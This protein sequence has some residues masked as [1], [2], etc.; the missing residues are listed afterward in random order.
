MFVHAAPPCGTCSRAREIARP[1]APRPLRTE[2]QPLGRDGLTATEQAR[3]DAANAI[4]A[5]LAD[6]F[7]RC[8]AMDIPWSVENPSRSLLWLIPCIR[9]LQDVTCACFYNYD[10]CA[11]GSKRLLQRSFLSTL[12]AMCGIQAL[13]ANDHEHLSLGRTRLPDASTKWDTAD[14]AA[15]TIPLCKQ[16]VSVVQNAL[17]LWPQKQSASTTNVAINQRG[18]VALQKQPRGRK[19]PPVMSEFAA[20]TTVQSTD[21]PPLDSKGCLLRAFHGVPM[22]SKLLSFSKVGGN[23]GEHKITCK[24]GIYRSPTA[25]LKDACMLAH[26]F[27]CYHAVPDAMLRVIFELLTNSPGDVAR[28][29]AERLKLWVSWAHQLD[30]QEKDLKRNLEAGVRAILQP[31][32]VLLMKRIAQEMDWPDMKLFDDMLAGFDIVGLQEPSHVFGLEPRPQIISAEELWDVSKFVRPALLGKVKSSEQDADLEELWRI[33]LEE[34][35][36]NGWMLGPFSVEQMHERTGGK[37]W[38]PVRRFGV[39]Q[40]SGDKTKLRPIDDYAENRVNSAFGYSDKL[41]LRTLDQVIWCA[42]AVVRCLHEGTV[43]FFLSDGSVLSG[44]L[45]EAYRNVDDGK[46]VISVLDLASA[47]KQFALSPSCRLMSIITL[48]EPSTGQ[49]KCFE[50]RVLPFGATASVVHFHRISKFLQAIGFQ[51]LVLWGNY[52]D[53]Y[54]MLSTKLLADSTMQTATTLLDLLGFEFAGHKLKPFAERASVLGVDLDLSSAV[55]DGVIRVYNKPSRVAE[56]G[57]LVRQVLDTQSITSKEASRLLGRLQFADSQ[58]M[59]RM[60]RLVMHDFRQHVRSHA[61]THSLDSSALGSLRMLLERLE[62]GK[63]KE[64]PCLPMGSPVVIFTDGASEGDDHTIGG[65]VVDGQDIEFFSCRV[66]EALIEKWQ[67]IF[68]HVIG[69][70]ELYAVLVAA[71]AW[72]SKITGRRSLFFIDNN[73][74]M[75]SLIKGTSGPQFYRELLERWECM[76]CVS[77]SWPWIARIPSHSNPADE[78]SRGLFDLMT[79]LKATRCDRVQCPVTGD[80]LRNL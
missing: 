53:D 72:A 17:K 11:W 42:A 1:N 69:L 61:P 52:F 16:I 44:R 27:D 29:R 25:W 36:A 31:K 79:S 45:H 39:W 67:S 3:V 74:A 8:H 78:P 62:K 47:Y 7:T 21:M 59:G 28:R 71:S 60:G 38:I 37:P 26:P 32:R 5:G 63:P 80:T 75:D 40:T 65:L 22:H 13:C 68:S 2:L 70:I 55:A 66:T 10:T 57:D 50:G 34:T 73:P 76:D 6:F 49:C 56:V 58:I 64:V 19:M 9:H 18:T 23:S 46:P 35:S 33:T 12:P 14:E 77:C 54:P 48:R 30:S 41:D 51:C 43:E 24:F 4:Y 15:Y 20:Q